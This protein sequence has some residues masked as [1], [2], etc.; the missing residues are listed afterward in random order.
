MKTAIHTR[1]KRMM[2]AALREFRTSMSSWGSSLPELAAVD[3][4]FA[5]YRGWMVTSGPAKRSMI[6]CR[7]ELCNLTF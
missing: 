5:V 3:D 2:W 4:S 6:K 7:G 1:P